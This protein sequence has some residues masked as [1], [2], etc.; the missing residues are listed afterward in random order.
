MLAVDRFSFEHALG[1]IEVSIEHLG[2]CEVVCVSGGDEPHIGSVVLA[3]KRALRSPA[4]A[5]A[6]PLQC[7]TASGTKTN[8]LPAR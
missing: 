4:K 5:Q 2:A 8:S 1:T 3:E 7:S 6:Q